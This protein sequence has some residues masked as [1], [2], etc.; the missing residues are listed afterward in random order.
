MCIFTLLP[1]QLFYQGGSIMEFQLVQEIL[2]EHIV[3]NAARL[4][5]MACFIVA[6][7]KV[8]SV[9]LSEIADAFPG[10]SQKDSKYKRIQRFFKNFILDL[11]LIAKLIVEFLPVKHESW[12]LSMDRTNWKFGRININIL[13]LGV[14]H[15]GVAF[16]IIWIPLAKRGNSNTAERISL[17]EKFLELFG[18]DKIDCLLGDREFIGREWFSYLLGKYIKFRL[19]IKENMLISNSKGILVPAKNLF[20]GLKVGEIRVLD[21]KRSVLGHKLFVIGLLL[22]DGEYVI[23]V[24][25]HDPE[26]AIDDYKKRW[27]IETLFGHLKKR[28]FNFEDTHMT[29][30]NK[31]SKLVAL[32]AIT[33]C[34]CHSTGEWLIDTVKAIPIKKHGRKSI[35]VFKYGL[36][37]IRNILLNITENKNK[38]DLKIVLKVLFQNWEPGKVIDFRR[39]IPKNQFLSCT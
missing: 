5:C 15:E 2:S 31:I 13:T 37:K 27:A 24:T 30:L 9:N 39:T 33:F 6:L 4:E 32:L 20:R 18:I 17:I 26:S 22:P 36:D 1:Y 3:I 34:L 12:A 28:G 7:I 35:S 25:N 38:K 23:L 19:R 10:Q 8:R 11:D 14:A 21:G 16:P 29:D